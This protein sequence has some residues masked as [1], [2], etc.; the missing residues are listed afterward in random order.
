MSTT[1]ENRKLRTAKII[2]TV[3]YFARLR[4][5]LGLAI[6]RLELP[7]AGSSVSTL[8]DLLRTRG[9]VWAEEL[10]ADRAVCIA[11]NQ[12]LAEPGTALRDG[13]EVAFFPPV[14]GG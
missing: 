8:R 5:S 11:V 14:T 6:E 10:A 4:Q 7:A 2:V 13:D 3:L 9:A 1:T 12:E